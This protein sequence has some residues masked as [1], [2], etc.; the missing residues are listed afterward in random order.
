MRLPVRCVP[1]AW[2]LPLLFLLCCHCQTTLYRSQL[3]VRDETSGKSS[4]TFVFDITGSMFDDLM[5]VRE[6]SRKIFQTVMQQREKLIYNY[7]MVPFHDPHLGEIIKTTDSA[8]FLRQLGKIYVHGG[9]D[10]QEPSLSG[11]KKA[12]EISLPSSFVYVF[13]DA[14]SKDYHLEDEVLNL[15]QEKQSSVV[16]VMTGDCG[17]RTHPG[18]RTYEKIAAA[19]FGQVFHLQKSDVSTVLEYVRHSV[20]QKKV[21]I[22]YEVREKGGTVVKKVPVDKHMT[23]LT[24]SLSGDKDDE[25]ILDI[26]LRDPNG[27]TVDKNVYNREGGTLDLKNVKLI[28]LKDPKPGDW[29]VITNSRLKHTIRVFGHGTIDFKYG[30]SSKPMNQIESTRPR[31]VANQNTYLMVNI[32]GLIPKGAVQEISLLDYYGNVIH[33][34]EATPHRNNHHMYFIGPFIPPKGLFFIKVKGVD[35]DNY[36]FERIAPTAIGS[37]TVGGPRGYM[38]PFQTAFV[39]KDVNLTCTVESPSPYQVYWRRGNQNIGG[40]LFYSST[41]T[42]IWTLPGVSLKDGGDYECFIV[43]NNGNHSVKTYL[44]IRESPP[45]IIGMRNESVPNGHPA[46]LHCPTQSATQSEIRWLRHGV[47]VLNGPNTLLYPNGTLRIHIASPS[48]S[49]FYECQAR[50]TGGMAS[51]TVFLKVLKLPKAAVYPSVLYFAPGTAFNISCRVEGDPQPIP[52]WFFNGRKIE[53]SHKY[54]ITF[55]NDLIVRSAL[56]EDAGTYECRAISP[57]GFH[58]D[59]ATVQLATPPKISF[60]QSKTIVARGDSVTFE[61]KV[62]EGLPLPT[63]HFLRNGREL[64]KSSHE[65]IHIDGGRMTIMGVQDADSGTYNCVAES[66][67]G[68]AIET[69][70]L[71][72]GSVPSIV[73]SPEIV[74]VNIEKP[75]TL[76]CRAIGHPPPTIVWLRDGVL[77]KQLNNPRYTLLPDGNLHITSAMMEDQSTFTCTATNN[78]GAQ[79]KSTAVKIT[80]LVAPVLGHVPPEEQLIEGKDLRLSCI[81]VLG[82]PTPQIQWYKDGKQ[83][84][85]GESVIVEGGGSSLLLRNG[86]PKDEGRYTCAAISPAGNATI[87]INVQLIKRPE[88]DVWIDPATGKPSDSQQKIVEWK[89]GQSLEIPCKVK[90]IPPPAVTWSLNGRPLSREDNRFTIKEDNTLVV[91]SLDKS[92]GGPYTCN[93]VN[94]AGDVEQTTTVTVIS[95]PIIQ[96]SQSSFNIIQGTS[97]TIPCDVFI[98]PKPEI[99]WYL[100][101][102]QFTGGTV[103]EDGSL[104]IENV[105]EIHKGELKCVSNNLAGQDE[106]VVTLTIHTAPIIEGSG[107]TIHRMAHVNDTV[108]LPCP[109]FASPPPVRIWS[110][111]SQKIDSMPIPHDISTDGDL[112]LQSVQLDAAGHYSCL[113]SNLAGDD[114]IT[115]QLEVQEKPRVIS[116]TA[117]AFDVVKGM[118]LELPCKA[119]GSPP[120][121]K[122]WEKDGIRITESDTVTVDSTGTLKIA[123]SDASHAGTWTCVV[124]NAVGE[125]RRDTN[126]VVQEPPVILPTTISN[127]TAVEGDLVELQCNVEATPPATIQWMRKGALV[128]EGTPGVRIEDDGTL[129]IEEASK[130]DSTSFTCK[131]SNP[132]GK[133]EKVIRLNV[134]APPD[135][136]DQDVIVQESVKVDQPF[137]LYCPV[138]GTPLPKITWQLNDAPLTESDKNYEISEDR[139]RL[140]FVKARPSDS[141]VYK[142]IARNPAGEGSKTFEVEVLVPLALNETTWKKKVT[143]KEGEFVELGCPVY[144]LP[145]PDINW[146]VNGRILKQGEEARGIK[147]GGNGQTIVINE[148][149][150]EHDGQYHCYAQSKAGSFDVDITLNVLAPPR[151]GK[152]ETIEL[153]RGKAA[154]LS[155]EVENDF[156]E[157]SVIK[158]TFNDS[159]PWPAN[160]QIPLDGQRIFL[161]DASVE[162]AGV[163][164]C[165]STNSA[166][167]NTKKITVTVI[168]PPEFVEKEYVDNVQVNSGSTIGLS[169]IVRGT[170]QPVIEWRRDG[171]T[172]TSGISDNGQRITVEAPPSTS[173]MTCLVTNKGGSISRDFFV[174]SVSAPTFKDTGVR[175]EVEVTE[176]QT[177]TLECPAEGDDFEIVWRRQGKKIEGGLVEN[178]EVIEGEELRLSCENDGDPPPKVEWK[179]VDHGDI[180]VR[181]Q[182]LHDNTVMVLD[183]SKQSDSGVFTC[184]LTN[185]VGVAEK[186]FNVKVIAKPQIDKDITEVNV[187]VSRPITLDCGVKDSVGDV[188]VVW[189]KQGE[190]IKTDETTQL[191]SNG[192]YLHIP[193]ATTEAEGSYQCVQSNKAGEGIKE[194][195]I[196]VQVPPS[197][198][199][200]GGEFSVT[201]NNSLV[202]PCDGRPVDDLK[203]VELLSEGQQFKIVHAD[204]SHKGSYICQR[205]LCLSGRIRADVGSFLPTNTN[206]LGSVL[207]GN[208]YLIK[209][210][211]NSGQIAD[212]LGQAKSEVGSAELSFDVDVITRPMITKGVNDTV[213]VI[214]GETAHFKCPIADPNFNGEIIWLINY[215]PIDFKSTQG[216]Y[217]LAQQDRRLNM[218]G[219]NMRDEGV[220]SCR[221]KNEAG[222]NT[223]DFKLVVLVPPK[224]IILDSDRNRSVVENSSL[225]LSCPATGNPEPTIVWLKDGEF[226]HPTNISQIIK[227]AHFVGNEIKIARIKDGDGGRYTC[228]ALNR[229]GRQEQD[230]LVTVMTPPRIEKDGIPSEIAEEAGKAVTLLCPAQGKVSRSTFMPLPL[231]KYFCAINKDSS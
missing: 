125:D 188:S 35:E 216:K 180:P 159:Q 41:E 176:G 131:A 183:E 190:D 204:P 101:G 89:E 160:V 111:E 133:A 171:Q 109:A 155:C 7:I 59:S 227:S 20:Q 142:C 116:E 179:K 184:T 78:Y 165:T 145:V 229:A 102:E 124:T 26:T 75:V 36:V 177:A 72:V 19:S 119:S 223:V 126:V 197:I 64:L 55:K 14:R 191:L 25:D 58:G 52:Q 46:F 230:V 105:D 156:Q 173:R 5:Q 4:L 148:A 99:T 215:Q 61:C 82:T 73:P 199:S 193:S 114:S 92:A 194:F 186:T 166:G 192:R 152:D 139:R 22:M 146:I 110:Y 87:H 118:S 40:P 96:P 103:G 84:V 211:T 181:A 112:I 108:T 104:T 13:T 129:V 65:Y 167:T 189:R 1:N 220:Y 115:Y 135:I 161:V 182:M 127:Y 175:T 228:E 69:V 30:F 218:M 79:S 141:G 100:N 210:P 93:A 209:L 202:L 39:G 90:A 158:W 222:D 117:Q 97:V 196:V 77:V 32:T 43:S 144:G 31:P 57:A 217:S 172:V 174:K 68:R 50:N 67:A 225:T 150:V 212:Q 37:V 49:G 11:I 201:E 24:L 123:E 138:F 200:E 132:A 206:P 122:V 130:E 56:R 219:A 15:I 6:G 198:M 107:Q 178:V 8:Y 151:L 162:N 86:N 120:P 214:E 12:L 157:K 187:N 71:E 60:T 149:K 21:H 27:N 81:V 53:A 207:V 44:E 45:F 33:S 143:V 9:G 226:L 62:I 94:V 208:F 213:E 106:K 3:A 88:F 153:I 164:V 80:G 113:V 70:K 83:I 34:A 10:C 205:N 85:T 121:G 136:P 42:S 231:L 18:F 163:Y 185:K 51:Q 76:Q 28:R 95:I 17:N 221:A 154:T 66:I 195:K 147:L 23:E 134:I 168:E 16:F 128:T 2:L 63:I 54:Y 74:H 48:D 170:P 224:I 47:S 169:C 203:S 38:A 29:Q 91:H 140:H 98:E 137:S